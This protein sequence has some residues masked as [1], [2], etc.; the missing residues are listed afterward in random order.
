[1]FAF[2]SRISHSSFSIL[3]SPFTIHQ[4]ASPDS[5][6][7]SFIRV[8][9]FLIS[10]SWI[11]LLHSPLF[12][13]H[14]PL[15]IHHFSLCTSRFTF[16]LFYSYLV[17][18]ILRHVSSNRS[19]RLHLSPEFLIHR[20]A[21]LDSRSA[22]LIRISC[23]AWCLSESQPVFAF[24][25]CIPIPRSAFSDSRFAS[26]I[27]ISDILNQTCISPF[28]FQLPS[29]KSDSRSIFAFCTSQ[30]PYTL[31]TYFLRFHFLLSRSSLWD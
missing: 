28:L 14:Y 21:F 26:P 16:C 19:S 11:R 23:F 31:W 17:S 13:T 22:S 24:I 20:S 29:A 18:R 12:I 9:H 8:S 5:R 10:G 1:V 6:F 15:S 4:F 27:H 30:F 3:H 2:A 25:P 7:A